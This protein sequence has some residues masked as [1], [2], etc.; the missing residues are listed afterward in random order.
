M[1]KKLKIDGIDKIIIK[2]L[3]NDARTPILSIAREVGISG[4]AIHQR[5]RKLDD[6]NLIDGYKMVLNPKALGYTTT[7]F[8]G[9][10]L[11]SAS[12]YSSAIKR[13]KDIPEVVE[14]HYTTGNYAIFI[15]IMCKNN[16]DLM[17]LLNKDIQNIKG[18][19][20]TETF[21]SLD[22]QIDRQIK[23]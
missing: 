2:R 13:L 23:I 22:Q 18:V 7:A 10:F 16:Q 5:L 8:V 3:V 17:H 4:A 14:S 11:E 20:R 15:K 12:L 6:S 19:S 21:I 1:S 9:I